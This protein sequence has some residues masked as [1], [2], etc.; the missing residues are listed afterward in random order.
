MGSGFMK[1]FESFFAEWFN[2]GMDSIKR[3]LGYG[4]KQRFKRNIIVDWFEKN[5]KD[6]ESS[7]GLMPSKYPI[8]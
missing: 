5:P 2:V 4:G 1:A 8:A 6:T 7:S 3:E